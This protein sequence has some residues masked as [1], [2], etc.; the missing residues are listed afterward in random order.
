LRERRL[1]RDFLRERR[2]LR[3][4]RRDLRERRLLR[5]FFDDF[6]DFLRERRERRLIRRRER[7][8]AR[9]DLFDERRD[10]RER[11]DL[12][13]RALICGLAGT[14][15]TWRSAAASAAP[16]FWSEI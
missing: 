6:R 4:P 8:L 12:R 9:R 2:D 7:R 5:D 3:E 16:A 14:E 15:P 1:L 10:L 11:L 13:R